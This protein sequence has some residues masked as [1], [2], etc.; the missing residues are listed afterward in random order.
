MIPKFW[1]I[2]G[3]VLSTLLG[4]HASVAQSVAVAPEVGCYALIPAERVVHGGAILLNKC[5]GDTHVLVRVYG[6]SKAREQRR[7]VVAYEWVRVRMRA[8]HVVESRKSVAKRGSKNC[9]VF[10]GREF[11]E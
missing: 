7:V 8:D 4:P 6:R 3:L 10:D 9:F 1:M 11:C 5:N 2:A